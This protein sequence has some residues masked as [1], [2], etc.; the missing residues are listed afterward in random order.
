[1]LDKKH[2]DMP[3]RAKNTALAAAV[4]LTAAVGFTLPAAATSYHGPHSV[5]A[6]RH[7]AMIRNHAYRVG[8][9]RGFRAGHYAAAEGVAPGEVE[10]GRSAYVAPSPVAQPGVFGNGGVLGLGLLGGNGLLGTGVLDGQGALGVGVLG[11]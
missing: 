6:L 10:T 9:A 3:I 4:A 8:Y 2:L 11:L 7:H 1:M 5:R